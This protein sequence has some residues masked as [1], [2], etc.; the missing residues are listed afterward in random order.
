V[1]ADRRRIAADEEGDRGER[2]GV[3]RPRV[4]IRAHALSVLRPRGLQGR[5]LRANLDSRVRGVVVTQEP[6]K[7]W[8]PVRIRSDALEADIGVRRTR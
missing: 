7:L 6:S 5:L 1:G 2:L 3:R 4:R 8:S